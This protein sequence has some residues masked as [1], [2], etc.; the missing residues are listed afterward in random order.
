MLESVMELTDIDNKLQNKIME[1]S[2]RVEHLIVEK[3][4]KLL[5]K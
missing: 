4:I 3:L 5:K 1:K 2:D